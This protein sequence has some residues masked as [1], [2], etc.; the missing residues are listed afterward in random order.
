MRKNIVIIGAG[1]HGR[2]VADIAKK[3]NI[4]KNV[5]F[6]DDTVTNQTSPEYKII[7][8]T[9]DTSKF[10]EN[11]DFFVAIGDNRVREKICSEL[12]L[13]E[14]HLVTLVHPSAVINSEVEIDVCTAIMAGVVINNNCK[15]GKGC[16]I[17]T[18][19]SLDHDNYIDDYA[20]ISPGVRCAGNVKI[21]KRTWLGIGSI[22]INNIVIVDD[23]IVGAG[24]VV[25]NDIIE[26]GT[27][28]GVPVRRLHL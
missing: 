25:I 27:Y 26:S 10:K 4:W 2:V 24:G 12:L 13:K 1:S 15:I 16:I 14:Y 19:S 5:S 6:I 22:V 17:N 18:S 11:S 23:C 28:V 20:H 3:M 8:T 21:G 7:G 9:A